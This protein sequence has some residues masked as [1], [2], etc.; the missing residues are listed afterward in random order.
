MIVSVGSIRGAPGST[1]WALLLAAAWPD[2]HAVERVV[3]EADPAGGVLGARYG[4]GVDPGVVRLVT[5]AR[6]NDSPDLPL[7]DIARNLDDGMWVIPGPESAERARGVWNESAVEVAQR[8]SVDDRVWVLDLGRLEETNPSCAFVRH[9]AM[10]VLVVGPRSEDLVQLPSRV[11]SL[12][13]AATGSIGVL[14]AGRSGFDQVEIAQFARA[15]R[16]WAVDASDGLVDEVGRVLAGRRG[17]RSW[18][19]RQALDVAGEVAE[20]AHK[21]VDSGVRP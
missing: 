16:A 12:R 10:T 21:S 17:R 7:Y 1:S 2:A 19:W 20:L 8:L 6:R 13:V 9:A 5:S 15:D 14:V 4:F 11:D 3:L 18:V